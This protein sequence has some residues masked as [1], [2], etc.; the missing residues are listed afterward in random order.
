MSNFEEERERK[1]EREKAA[2]AATKTLCGSSRKKSMA[3]KCGMNEKS[4]DDATQEY[5]MI[6]SR[7]IAMIAIYHYTKT[8]V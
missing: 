4:V 6:E 2:Y 5:Y 8:F 3:K 7:R 1:K